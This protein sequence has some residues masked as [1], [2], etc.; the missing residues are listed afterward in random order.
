[1]RWQ[2]IISEELLFLFT[3]SALQCAYYQK[4]VQGA[5]SMNLF[6]HACMYFMHIPANIILR[7]LLCSNTSDSQ[8]AINDD[9]AD[10]DLFVLFLLPNLVNPPEVRCRHDVSPLFLTHTY[11]QT[12]TYIH[13]HIH[14]GGNRGT[15]IGSPAYLL[16][17]CLQGMDRA[18]PVYKGVGFMVSLTV[19]NKHLP[20]CAAGSQQQE[21]CTWSGR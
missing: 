6:T 21:P 20:I 8:S 1:M 10:Q 3:Y 11:I 4:C 14:T 5:Y 12:Y 2:L 16:S 9:L 7:S 18:C 13:T 19:S 17:V 15:S